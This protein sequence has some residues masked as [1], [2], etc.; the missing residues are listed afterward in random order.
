MKITDT[1][2]REVIADAKLVKETALETAKLQLQEELTPEIQSIISKKLNESEKPGTKFNDEKVTASKE[3]GDPGKGKHVDSEQGSGKNE[4]P[5]TAKE[6]DQATAAPAA[7]APNH[8]VKISKDSDPGEGDHVDSEI[9]SGKNEN[10]EGKAKEND[11]AS[12]EVAGT[13]TAKDSGVKTESVDKYARAHGAQEIE[14]ADM[15][16]EAIIRE[17]ESDASEDDD[18]DFDLDGAG[19][20]DIEVHHDAP[21]MGHGEDLDGNSGEIP[22]AADMHPAHG[23]EGEMGGEHGEHG[24]HDED[25]DDV[26][27]GINLESVLREIRDEDTKES[28]V[29]IAQLK[30]ENAELRASLTEHK[31]VVAI[32]HSRLNE[33]NLLNAKLLYTNKLFK[34]YNLQEEQK[35]HTILQF[36]R[37]NN[38]RETKIVYSTLA[39]T[40]KAI[41]TAGRTKQSIDTTKV[42][43]EG[44]VSKPIGS[45]KP[46]ELISE[47]A[48]TKTSELSPLAKRFQEL[49]HIT[50]KTF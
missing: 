16:L 18:L 20:T 26:Y 35:A 9:G 13:G 31:K 7:K 8:G 36:D 15:D 44:M 37:A 1:Y 6:N 11:F 3:A 46:A 10:P 28:K 17:L 47:S 45:T 4:N 48:Q 39:E 40:Y 32:C 41:P 24:D 29:T 30:K 5:G 38:L 14:E 23:G 27:E 2:L 25:E 49:A 12:G 50:K 19:D 42:V 22:G 34:N 21:E 43:T 33:I